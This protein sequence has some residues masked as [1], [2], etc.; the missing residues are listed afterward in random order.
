VGNLVTAHP[1]AGDGI[2][3]ELEEMSIGVMQQLL[4]LL[5]C[6][7]TGLEKRIASGR[8]IFGIRPNAGGFLRDSNAALWGGESVVVFLASQSH[9]SYVQSVDSV[10]RSG[11]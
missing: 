6:D 5:G 8:A 2:F 3:A 9:Q 1:V 4:E 7:A 11:Q 10:T